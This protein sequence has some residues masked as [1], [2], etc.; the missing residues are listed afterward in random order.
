MAHTDFDTAAATWD[1]DPAKLERSRVVAEGIAAAVPL[2]SVSDAIEYGCGTGQVTWSLADRLHHVELLDASPG[3]IRVVDERIAALPASEQK[4]F[5]ARVFDVTTEALSASSVDLI[6]A[7]MALHHVSDVPLALRRFHDALRAGGHLAIADL[8]HD[9]LGH[10]HGEHFDGHHGF[11]RGA[12]SD[13]MVAAGFA[14]PT[15]TTLT[16]IPKEFDGE[17]HEFPVFLAVTRPA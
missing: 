17:S 5:S 13:A 3:M 6:Y 9:P 11:D 2:A 1:D 7:S 14:A 15:F 12:L 10:F 16:T 8:D 4:R